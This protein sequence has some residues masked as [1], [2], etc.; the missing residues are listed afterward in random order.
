MKFVHSADFHFNRPFSSLDSEKAAE[1]L[2]EE[3]FESL[4][5]VCKI[6]KDCD[7]LLIAGDLFDSPNVGSAVF[8]RVCDLLK[9]VPRVFISPGNHDESVYGKYVFPENVHVF[10]NKTEGI[11]CGDFVVWGNRGCEIGN[12]DI[13]ESKINLLC[14]H[15]QLD[16]SDYNGITENELCSYGFDYAALGHVHKYSGIVLKNGTRY[17]YSGCP[18]GGGFDEQGD[19]GAISAEITKDFFSADFEVCARR[20]FR[21]ITVNLSNAESYDDIKLPEANKTDLYKIILRGTV[22]EDFVIRPDVF[23]EKIK[24]GYFFVKIYN[25]TSVHIPYEDMAKEYSLKGIFVSKMLEKIKAEPEN[26]E[27]IRALELGV[28]VLEGKKVG[29]CL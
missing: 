26:T 20:R 27:L 24:D 4:K 28:R 17:A 3:Q 2:R 23:R 8:K 22:S 7:A 29:D 14:I 18:C 1:I 10:E 11:D 25:E 12:I 5:K 9:D 19:C 15:T 21:E 13:D 16:G 6:S